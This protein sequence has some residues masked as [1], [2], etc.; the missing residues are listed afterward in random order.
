M[1]YENVFRKIWEMVFFVYSFLC[2]MNVLVV[3]LKIVEELMCFFKEDL[4]FFFVNNI[5]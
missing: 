2:V 3:F 4:I 1:F 5:M